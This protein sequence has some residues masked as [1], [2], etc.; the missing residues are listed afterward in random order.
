MVKS[1]IIVP[2]TSNK[3]LHEPDNKTAHN[4]SI[5]ESKRP[6]IELNEVGQERSKRLFGVL[7]GTLNKFKSETLQNSEV[8][9]K[10]KEIDNKL[11]EK[12]E[13][14]KKELAAKISAREEEK[15]RMIE[16]KKRQEQL[17]IEEKRELLK[18]EESN[19]LA[20]YLKTENKP[21][22]Y[23]LPHQLTDEM[24]QKIEKQKE[25]ALMIRKEYEIRRENRMNEGDEI[26]AEVRE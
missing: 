17:K 14:E 12:L 25:E 20:Y 18:V 22:I 7:L 1:S 11:H 23:Y 5:E 26:K 8:D 21:C 16:L 15:N 10:R 9:R 24:K 6:R 19:L 13:L 4:D 2:A 3:R